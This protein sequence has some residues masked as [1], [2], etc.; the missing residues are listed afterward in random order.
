MRNVVFLTVYIYMQSLESFS[1]MTSILREWI[2]A[3]TKNDI[4]TTRGTKLNK[5]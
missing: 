4:T 2:L 1:Q 5:T 3:K